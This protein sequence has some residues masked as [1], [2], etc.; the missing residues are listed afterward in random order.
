MVSIILKNNQF[1]FEVYDKEKDDE[2]FDEAIDRA[3]MVAKN[4]QS[5]VTLV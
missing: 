4:F 5:N 2:V 3:G 1:I